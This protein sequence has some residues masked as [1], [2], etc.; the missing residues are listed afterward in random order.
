MAARDAAAASI[1]IQ[2]RTSPRKPSTSATPS[3]GP[4]RC[5]ARC[6]QIGPSGSSAENLLDQSQALLD[7][8]D[9]DPDAGVDVAFGQHR[10]V[11]V[12][13][14]VGRI[15]RRRAA[16]RRR[17][18]EARPTI[19]AG[20]ELLR[21]VRRARRRCRRCGPAARRCCRRARPARGN[22][23]RIVAQQRRGSPRAPGASRSAATPPGTTRSIISRWPKQARAARSTCSRSTP[24]CACM[25][26][27]AASLQM[28]PMSPRWLA[29][30][31]SSAIS[32]RSQTRARRRVEPSAASTARAK[33]MA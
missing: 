31:S 18:R 10:D 11:E 21:A 22:A 23:R 2:T 8:A 15:A 6:A 12:E 25:S 7:L 26:A 29:S 14:V 13:L 9:A 17:G 28:A 5:R 32:A 16:R 19:A 3:H 4:A 20:A 30:R 27:K 33:A 1:R 24:Q